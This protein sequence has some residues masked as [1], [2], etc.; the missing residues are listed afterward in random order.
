MI[1][2]V[3][4]AQ[5]TTAQAPDYAEHLRDRVL[6]ALRAVN[7]YRGA[8]LLRRATPEGVE[9]IVITFWQSLAATRGF[10]GADLEGGAIVAEEAAA[11]LTRFDS[12]A[13]HYEVEL[14]DDVQ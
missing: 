1:A 11:L 14:S 12:R 6:P 7:A 10:A 5:T 3:W 9:F 4:S 2:R 13:R 8:R